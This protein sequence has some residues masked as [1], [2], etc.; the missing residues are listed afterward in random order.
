MILSSI[1]SKTKPI[2][3]VLLFSYLLLIFLITTFSGLRTFA[4]KG[5]LANYFIIMGLLAMIVFL[6]EFICK[7]NNLSANNNFVIYVFITLLSIFPAIFFYPKLVVAIFFVLLALRKIITLKSQIGV[8]RKIFDA[9]LWIG[10]AILCYNWILFLL[11]PLFVAIAIYAGNSFRNLLIPFVAISTVFILSYTTF[12][13][14]DMQEQFKAL[15]SFQVFIK[16]E[17][18]T[19]AY[20]WV[21]TALFMIL[22]IISV[23]TFFFSLKTKTTSV[24]NSLLIV[25]LTLCA[26]ILAI[27]LGN[28]LEGASYTL[29][30]FPLA[31]FTGNYLEQL[32]K[33]RFREGL[34]WVFC[35]L[36]FLNLLL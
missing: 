23:L 29:L 7:R 28:K 34:L 1:F 12:L 13:L 3:F 21:P 2:N 24:K 19:M 26:S 16:Q 9:A 30:I 32:T 6:V 10:V 33:K 27:V 35:L 36:P 5:S 18:F 14:L 4:A 8:K 22:T 11:I 20:L 17:Y 15:L 25:L 31:I